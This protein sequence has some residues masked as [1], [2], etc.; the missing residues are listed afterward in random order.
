MSKKIRAI[1]QRR[2]L[3]V[4]R[5]WHEGNAFSPHPANHAAFERYEWQSGPSALGAARGTATEL[6]GVAA[7][8]AAQPEWDVVVL[9]CAAALPA[10]P[11]DDGLFE[12]FLDDVRAG[13]I[14]GAADGAWDAIYL[15]LHGAAITGSRLTPD[16]EILKLVRGLLPETPIGASFDLHG[17]MSPETADIVDVAS[18]YRTYPHVDMAETAS[19]VLEGLRRCVEDGLRTHR[20]LLNEGLVLPSF[21]MRTEA[22]PM[23]ELE[24]LA[25]AEEQGAV[26]E[27]SIFG[28]FPYADT[29]VTG[30]SVLIISDRNKDAGG[31]AAAA[32]AARLMKAM[33]AHS[34]QFE[35][36]LPSPAEA[37][38]LALSSEKPGLIAITDP[39]D[40]P[41]SG[42]SGDTPMLVR[43]LLSARPNVPS[44]FASFADPGIV[45]IAVRAGRGATIE[46]TLGGRFGRHF[47]ESVSLHATV[48]LLTDGCFRNVGPMEH[49]VERRCGG[50]VLLT[51]A[52][53]PLIRVIVTRQVIAADDPAFYELHGID[54]GQLRLLCVKAKNHFR[55][56]FA[57]RC[58]LIVDCDAPGPAMA[59]LSGLPFQHLL[60]KSRIRAAAK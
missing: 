16:L 3:A 41:L 33:Q 48:G 22:G 34:P 5:F 40:N 31:S 60:L 28:G 18:A 50:S 12:T 47:G 59:D 51:I 53:Q 2:R 52:Q 37:V 7:F 54:L 8:A 20:V 26:L 11:V 15:S 21:N 6:G 1:K 35:V 13:L 14:A 39:A 32:A 24:R 56:A 23:H 38:A 45:D 9:R 58:S 4:V 27:A 30:A 43:A 10:G 55:A 29:P 25:R 42:G 44:L 17:N 19:R 36:C 49:G 46:V 57:A